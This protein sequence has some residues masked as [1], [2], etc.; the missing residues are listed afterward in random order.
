MVSPYGYSCRGSTSANG[1]R[2]EF[3][4]SDSLRVFRRTNYKTGYWTDYNLVQEKQIGLF[5]INSQGVAINSI[6]LISLAL[7]M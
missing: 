7:R 1:T 6:P 3:I 2:Q 4:P 5:K